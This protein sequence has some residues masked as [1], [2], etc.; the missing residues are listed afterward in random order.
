MQ[1]LKRQLRA[2]AR[3]QGHDLSAG[4]FEML[5]VGNGHT[6]DDTFATG[7]EFEQDLGANIIHRQTVVV[8]ETEIATGLAY[9]LTPFQ[10]ADPGA[11]GPVGHMYL[12]HQSGT[13]TAATNRLLG[14]EDIADLTLDGA[15]DQI[16]DQAGGLLQLVQA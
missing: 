12:L 11:G 9:D 10:F 14:H 15:A 7:D 16:N 8:A 2:M 13:N 1:W 3:Q 6:P 4:V 5:F